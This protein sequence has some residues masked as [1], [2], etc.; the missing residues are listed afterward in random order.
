[1]FA[2]LL[3]LSAVTASTSSARP[4]GEPLFDTS[5]DLDLALTAGGLLGTAALYVEG[6]LLVKPTCPCAPRS[7]NGF[8]RGVIGER[9][10]AADLASTGTV[11]LLMV[12]PLAIDAWLLGGVHGVFLDDALVFGEVLALNAVAVSLVKTAVQR[13]LPLS[14]SG[15]PRFVHSPSGYRSFYSGH[16]STAFAAATFGALLL[17]RR[18]VPGAVV[19]PAALVLAGSVGLERLEAGR[20]FPSDVLVGAAAGALVAIVVAKTHEHHA[21]VA[22]SVVPTTDGAAAGVSGRF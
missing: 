18:G 20:H 9:S 12:A 22:L 16:T 17:E 1:M 7:V 21:K 19:W 15:D 3:V 13:P 8:D 2:A 11:A 4:A 14:Y 6:P 10:G 5:P